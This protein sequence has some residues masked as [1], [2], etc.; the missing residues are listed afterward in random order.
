MRP[1]LSAL[2]WHVIPSAHLSCHSY[3]DSKQGPR[4]KEEKEVE[5]KE[6]EEEEETYF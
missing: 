5:V 4:K 3:W 6:E 1:T 2:K